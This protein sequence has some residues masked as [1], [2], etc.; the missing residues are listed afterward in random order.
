MKQQNTLSLKYLN[1]ESSPQIEHFSLC[2]DLL[3]SISSSCTTQYHNV[4]GSPIK[5]VS[6]D[7]IWP[8]AFRMSGHHGSTARLHCHV[9]WNTFYP[10]PKTPEYWCMYERNRQSRRLLRSVNTGNNLEN[11]KYKSNTAMGNNLDVL[12]VPVALLD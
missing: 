8:T 11:G 9:S 6:K 4:T 5:Y 1:S 3:L 12:G 10:L 2:N 7:C